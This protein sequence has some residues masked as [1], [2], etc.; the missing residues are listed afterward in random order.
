MPDKTDKEVA[1]DNPKTRKKGSSK[2]EQQEPKG[3]KPAYNDK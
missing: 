1:E 3:G 2:K